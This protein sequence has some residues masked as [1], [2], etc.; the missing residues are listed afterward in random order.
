MEEDFRARNNLLPGWLRGV[1]CPVCGQDDLRIEHPYN[2]PD[3]VV[4]KVCRMAFVVADDDNHIRLSEG[5]DWLPA[6][7][8]GQWVTRENLRDQLAKLGRKP[9]YETVM[10]SRQAGAGA[11]DP[12]LVLGRAQGLLALGNSPEKIRA[13]LT[14]QY[15]ADPALIEQVM[16]G[17]ALPKPTRHQIDRMWF[18]AGGVFLVGAL[19]VAITLLL[20]PP[21]PISSSTAR[22]VEVSEALSNLLPSGAKVLQINP[23]IIRPQAATGQVARNCPLKEGQASATFG[24]KSTDWRS[25]DYGWLVM[26]PKPFPIYLP[27]G[28][29][30]NY[31]DLNAP[32][33]LTEVSGPAAIENAN[34][35]AIYCR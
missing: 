19:V 16:D 12:K 18:L 26:T 3:R 6:E 5:P 29:K 10:P 25:T 34:F 7:W 2:A 11:V 33:K 27:E 9:K 24:G 8:V 20:V 22:P 31:L 30:A 32:T 35:L 13:L 14:E 17:L 4:C 1:S 21:K 15:G 23:V 28:M